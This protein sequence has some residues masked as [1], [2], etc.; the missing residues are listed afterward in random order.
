M[1]TYL[2]S[3]GYTLLHV[4]IARTVSTIFKLSATWVGPRLMRRTDT[5]RGGIWSFSWQMIWLAVGVTLLFI[6]AGHSQEGVNNSISATGLAV[7]VALSYVGL[8]GYDLCSQ[9]IIQEVGRLLLTH[10]PVAVLMWTSF[11]GSRTGS[12]RVI[13]SSGDVVS[14]HLRVNL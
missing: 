7:G 3:V 4:G 10:V 13:L 12:P 1:I 11:A 8:W 5:I 2:I 9:D 6:D 14:E